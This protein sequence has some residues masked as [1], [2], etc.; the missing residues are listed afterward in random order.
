MVF[1]VDRG[2]EGYIKWERDFGV[3]GRVYCD[4]GSG[5]WRVGIGEVFTEYEVLVDGNV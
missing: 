1:R 4:K 5:K 2:G 3:L